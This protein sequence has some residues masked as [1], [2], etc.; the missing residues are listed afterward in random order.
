M[1]NIC[2]FIPFFLL[3]VVIKTEA[4]GLSSDYYYYRL[5]FLSTKEERIFH[6]GSM[7]ACTF[8]LGNVWWGERAR[9]ATHIAL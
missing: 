3:C 6:K 2:S 1:L 5:R 4:S 8:E 7:F 9:L